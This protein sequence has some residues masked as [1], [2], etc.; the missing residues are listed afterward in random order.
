VSCVHI[1]IV[2]YDGFDE[3]DAIGPLEVFR[4]AQRFGAKIKA[5]LITRQ[6]QD[7]VMGSHGLIVV[8]DSVYA[9]GSYDALLVSGGGWGDRAEAGV[10][11]EVAR[12]DWLPILAGEAAAG[13]QMYSVCTGA[14]LLAHAG[15]IGIRRA[16]THHTAWTDLAATGAAL[17]KERVV[18]EGAL[19]TAGG[20]TSGIDLALHIVAREAGP[21]IAERVAAVLEYQ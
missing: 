11:G 6:P 20:V 4:N 7:Q 12:G 2:I 5:S 21:A 17:V 1:G 15:V 3:L 16:A 13:T 18:D 9:L 19:V 10:W 14:M 8:A